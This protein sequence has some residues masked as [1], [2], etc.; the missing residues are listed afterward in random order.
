MR[1]IGKVQ[2]RI[3]N[4]D[5]SLL[6][7]SPLLRHNTCPMHGNE[8]F[9]TFSGMSYLS[10]IVRGFTGRIVVTKKGPVLCAAFTAF[11]L[12]R[13]ASGGSNC[14]RVPSSIHSNQI[15]SSRFT[16]RLGKK[17][18]MGWLGSL[19]SSES[20]ISSRTASTPTRCPERSTEYCWKICGRVE[21]RQ[22]IQSR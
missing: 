1:R 14:I 21:S 19:F 8:R 7:P 6:R 3:N 16:L 5:R 12:R 2:R 13:E 4:V 22:S 20:R 11:K 10:V 9:S 17:Q 18:V 15:P